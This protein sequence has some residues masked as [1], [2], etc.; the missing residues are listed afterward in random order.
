MIGDG[1]GD[2]EEGIIKHTHTNIDRHEKKKIGQ[3][4]YFENTNPVYL[5]NVNLLIAVGHFKQF[6]FL[7]FCNLKFTKNGLLK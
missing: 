7:F 1:G 5:L 2:V 4:I 3:R 6:F